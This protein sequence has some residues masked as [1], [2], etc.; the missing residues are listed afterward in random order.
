MSSLITQI[1]DKLT[2]IP[3]QPNGDMLL[4]PTDFG[5]P[6]M[7][8]FFE[9]VLYQESL[10]LQAAEK[11]P[12]GPETITVKGTAGI[13]GYK[14]LQLTIT[15]NVQDEEVVGTVIAIFPNSYQP[16]MP[17]LTW[18]KAGNISFVTSL[19]EKYSLIAFQFNLRVLTDAITTNGVPVQLQNCTGS[20]WDIKIVEGTDQGITPAELTSLLAGQNI[21]E[22]LPATLA[23]ILQGF[24]LNSL[25]VNYDTTLS[26]VS[27]FTTGF[28]VTN[29]WTIVDKQVVLLPGLQINLTLI[30]PLDSA[31]RATT[32]NVIGTFQLG[33]VNVPVYLGASFGSTT[34]WSFGLQPNETVT[35]P[36]FSDLLALAGGPAFMN[37]LPAGLSTIPQ[38]VINT[39]F[40]TFDATNSVLTRL[41]FEVATASSWTII[42]DYFSIEKISI[43]FDITNLTDPLSRRI[44]GQLYGIFKVG[45][46]NFLM[47]SLDKTEENPE[48]AITVGLAPG[49]TLSLTAIAMQ[50]F[51]G[52]ITV[53]EGIPDFAFSVLEIMVVPATQ[54]F[55]FDAQS[56]NKWQITNNISI[57]VFKL[58]FLRDPVDP[59][60]PI[61]GSVSTVL[62]ISK[63]GVN[64][65]ASLNNTP[66]GGW[67]FDGSTKEGDP[68][69][70]GDVIAYVMEKFGVSRPPDWIRT[71]TLLNLSAAFNS[72]TKNFAFGATA[73]IIFTTTE[74]GIT[75]KFALN[76]GANNTYTLVLDGTITIKHASGNG[77]SIF[78]INF[79]TGTTDT[80]LKASWEATS[81]T[82]YLQLADI[83]NAFGFDL[84][85]IPAGLD[86]ALKSASLLYDFTTSTLAFT[87]QSANYGKA[88]FVAMKNPVN[89]QWV[90]FFGLS[91]NCVIDLANLP[92]INKLTFLD[93]GKLEISGINVNVVSA[94]TDKVMAAAINNQI[95][96]LVTDYN[97][98]PHLPAEGMNGTVS[99]SMT[100]NIGGTLYPINLVLGGDVAETLYL[101]EHAGVV[102]LAANDAVKTKW[103]E[104][105]K[106]FGPLYFDKI[107]V[108]Y[109]NSRI[110]VL[111]NVTA[112]A[113]GLSLGLNGFGISSAISSF[114]IAFNLDGISITY[115]NGP[116]LITGGLM[117]SFSPVN[118]YGDIL[119][120]TTALAIGGIGGYTEVGGKPSMFLYAVLNFPIGG[121]PFFFITGLSAGFGFNRKLVI[122]DITGVASFPFVV[123]SMPGSS[124]PVP[125]PTKDLKG[126]INAVLADIEQQGIVAPEVGSSWLAAGIN[127]TSFEM[128]NSFALLTVVFGTQVEVDLLGLS[129]LVIP[130]G[131]GGSTG[132][133]AVAF[134]ELA[135]KASY[136]FGSGLVSIQG[137][138][139]D[140]SYVLAK[141][142][143]LTGGFAFYFWFSGVHAGDFVITLGGYNPNYTPP[144]YYPRVPR[145]GINWKVDGNL[146]IRGSL[147]FAL[148]SN[149]VMAG[150]LMEAVWQSG[151]IRAWFLLQADFLIMWKPFHYDIVANTDIGAS[152]TI[153]LLFTSKTITIHVGVGIHVWGPEFSGKA[154]IDLAIISFT[155][156][157]GAGDKNKVQTISWKKFT[158][159]MLPQQPAAKAAGAKTLQTGSKADVCKIKVSD[160]LLMQ[161]SDDEGVLNWIVSAEK[162]T[163]DTTSII[164]SK[165]WN[166]ENVIYTDITIIL[167]P[168]VPAPLQNIDFGVR[169]V[170]LSSGAFN[171]TQV[172][173]VSASSGEK[174]VFHAIP[175]LSNIPKGLWQKI[176]FDRNGNPIIG[177]PVE[178]TTLT[179]VLTGFTLVPYKDVPAETL[180]IDLEYLKFTLDPQIQDFSWTK[181]YI[182]DNDPF[183]AET[184]PDTIMAPRALANRPMILNAINN[185]LFNV[186]THVNVD[187][188]ADAASYYLE[189]PPVLRLLGEEKK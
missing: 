44:Y 124:A 162:F 171:S 33:G 41:S 175:V 185:N 140:N 75:V 110:Y 126:Q 183:V 37:S 20:Q 32:A 122:P 71:I 100:V 155:I 30:N 135:I 60:T 7:N 107:G 73:K 34:E 143:H 93:A 127:F 91:S 169:P 148:T 11:I 180:P 45:A 49:K 118:L 80:R 84:P 144:N 13:L 129:R 89:Q 133:P 109:K 95:Q 134:A 167:H 161:L 184:V 52:T 21:S 63:V 23:S 139:T 5:L 138:L 159:E 48:W 39:L 173:E 66:D 165:D 3:I 38:I 51:E 72:T 136:V 157:F 8:T 178:D 132:V 117:G 182:P 150:G 160:G 170:G 18:I 137:Q 1:I 79:T 115:N 27:Y 152:F 146:L 101:P 153:N 97:A 24:T 22:F 87:L 46:T 103:F 179:N 116:I 174:A 131:T 187:E 61:K 57:D 6:Y 113:S 119:I 58:F 189:A 128:V 43:G 4:L 81:P 164:P 15:F 19:S 156:S 14:E 36:S 163:L 186:D 29:G 59:V 142:C 82:E 67:Q 42:A 112:T 188:L 111:V 35:L 26:Q 114:D 85:E 94:V 65:S 47:A 149:A 147:Y 99:F 120:K 108:G 177:N 76:N 158:E 104:I 123:W 56:A 125:D 74:L 31:R 77:E 17:V 64:L 130:P 121:P 25:D 53:P 62:Q 181:T 154:T 68:I 28:S 105:Q 55:R 151:G 12:P 90:F 69:V 78:R 172:L 92:I 88:V 141:A 10:L 16:S 40:T 98:Y 102:E 106:N 50:L 145:L 96:A 54:T 2:A 176:L 9:K 168:D 83:V 166:F 70:I 86:L